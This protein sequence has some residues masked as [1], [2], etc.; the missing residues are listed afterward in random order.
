[1][2][3]EITSNGYLK[4]VKESYSKSRRWVR[5]TLK[6]WLFDAANLVYIFAAPRLQ[7]FNNRP[8]AFERACAF[9]AYAQSLENT[10]SSAARSEQ[11][12]NSIRC[13]ESAYQYDDKR[14]WFNDSLKSPPDQHIDDRVCHQHGPGSHKGCCESMARED[15]DLSP[16]MRPNLVKRLHGRVVV[17]KF[18]LNYI[19][20]TYLGGYTLG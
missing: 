19:M 10:D 16:W 20:I 8:H 13:I 6:I 17:Q 3:L 11:L 14:N 4:T 5:P 15:A 18:H 7:A 12:Q 1:M 2:S 9:K